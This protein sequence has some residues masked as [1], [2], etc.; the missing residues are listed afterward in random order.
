MPLQ[1]WESAPDQVRCDFKSSEAGPR[2]EYL[3]TSQ[4]VVRLP[5]RRAGGGAIGTPGEGV[6]AVDQVKGTLVCRPG[7][8][9]PTVIDTPLVPLSAQG[10]AQ[11]VGSFSS[12]TAA[13]SPM[14]VAFLL[15]NANGAWI[16]NGSVRVP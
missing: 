9:S 4:R 2:Q 14:D 12:S 11:F 15:R 8:A 13:C 16:G 6:N 10:N 3:H 5:G 1:V 7:S